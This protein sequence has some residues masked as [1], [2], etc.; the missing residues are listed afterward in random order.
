M[1][2]T[3][4]FASSVILYRVPD[5]SD[6]ANTCPFEIL[7]IQ[8]AKGMKFLGGV[9]AFPGGK[10]EEDDISEKNLTKCQFTKTR[11]HQLILDKNTHHE[12]ENYSLGFWI[13]AIREVFE[14]IGVLFAYDKSL[15]L[16]NLSTPPLQTKFEAYRTQLLQD[17]ILFSE[18]M[19]REHLSFAVDKLHYFRHF[20]TPELSPIRYDTRFFLA[21]LPANQ[22]IKPDAREII[23]AE[24]NDPTSTMKRYHDKEIILIP[25]QYSCLLSLQKVVNI[26]DYCSSL[27]KC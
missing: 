13:T 4:K 17:Q 19:D 11:A 9:Y 6:A 12:N 21:E 22:I 10:L 18:I 27:Y 5:V 25:P 1:V 20:I 16:F 7:L 24:W 26:K 23:S 14:E 3:P 15:H 8:R 2:A